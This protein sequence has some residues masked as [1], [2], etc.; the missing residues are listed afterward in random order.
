MIA[1]ACVDDNWAIGKD[2][3]LL[4]HYKEDMDVFKKITIGKHIIM[5]RK[6]FES[7]PNQSPLPG[8]TNVVITSDKTFVDNRVTVLKSK[9]DVIDY[10]NNIN[11]Q[12]VLIGGEMVYKEFI[13]DCNIAIVTHVHKKV[14]DANKFFPNLTEMKNW[15]E[16]ESGI[17]PITVNDGTELEF[18]MYMNMKL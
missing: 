13:N 15:K 9:E 5:G 14:E 3:E 11:S 18:K 6:T 10:I 1:I 7:L 12:S 4:F 8:R 2:N 17:A 16:V